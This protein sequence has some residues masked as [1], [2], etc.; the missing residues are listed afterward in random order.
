MTAATERGLRADAAR[1]VNAILRAARAV[2]AEAGP[3]ASLEAIAARAGVGERTLYRRF[4]GKA[5]LIRAALD[6]SIAENL[7]P[8]IEKALRSADPLRGLATLFET[9][10]ALGAI[11][12]NLLAAARKA[13]ALTNISDSLDVAMSELAGRAQ[14]DGLVRP[15]VVGEDLTRIVVMLNSLL[16][17]MDPG[18][19]GWR[20]YLALF[21]DAISTAPPRRL[22]RA[23]P[24]RLADSDD[25]WPV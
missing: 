12:H 8:T 25:S 23:A 21:L 22:P 5:E 11:E 1:N 17:T 18:S 15:D 20:R 2:Y 6:Q 14:H 19:K 7:T 10:T 13:G 4:P 3:D 9:A 24:L 16:W